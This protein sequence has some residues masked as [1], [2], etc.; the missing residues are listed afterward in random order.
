M[1]PCFTSQC[2]LK[3]A[4]PW[5]MTR[6]SA[7]SD[8]QF[9]YFNPSG[10]NLVYRYKWSTE[11]WEQLPRC[12][13]RDFGLAVFDGELLAVGGKH[14]SIY[15]DRVFTLRRMKWM[16]LPS[17]NTARSCPAVVSTSKYLIAIGGYAGV[18]IS[19]VEL[20]QIHGGSW[21]SLEIRNDVR[22]LRSPSAL[23]CGEEIHIIECGSELRGYS[24]Y[25]P[26][27]LYTSPFELHSRLQ[28]TNPLPRPP[29][30]INSVT[31]ASLNGKLV[32]IGGERCG[33]PVNTIYKLDGGHWVAIGNMCFA[34][35]NCLAMNKSDKEILIVG[36]IG[37]KGVEYS[38]EEYS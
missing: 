28:Y 32:L 38:V 25:L 12:P 27:L 34:R 17:L 29:L 31:P 7:T 22:P 37:K 30:P 21:K 3:Q 13:Q 5:G 11:V 2:H 19:S 1:K 36:G 24:Y 16:D 26:S 14:R 18:W 20:L 15:S 8:G 33:I 35:K 23:V 9:A 4:A 6:G 10:T